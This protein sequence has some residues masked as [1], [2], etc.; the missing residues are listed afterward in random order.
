MLNCTSDVVNQKPNTHYQVWGKFRSGYRDNMAMT[1]SVNDYL[2]DVESIKS[3]HSI[4]G[5]YDLVFKKAA[6]ANAGEHTCYDDGNKD[7]KIIVHVLVLSE[8]FFFC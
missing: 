7:S 2:V 5:R 8:F 3:L 6:L 4:R 1:I